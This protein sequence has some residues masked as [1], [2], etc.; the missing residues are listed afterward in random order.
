[1]IYFNKQNQKILFD[2]F[3]NALHSEGILFVGHS[4]SLFSISNRFELIGKT[5]YMKRD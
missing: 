2:R 1:V 4:E 5:V 3:A